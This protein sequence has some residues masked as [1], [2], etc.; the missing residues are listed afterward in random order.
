MKKLF[1]FLW[2]L[3]TFNLSYGNH[4][5]GGW[6]F[7]TY[8][9]PGASP[10]T[11]RYQ[12]ILKIYT[13]C[14][15]NAQQWC[16]TVNIS[17]FN[18]ASNNLFDVVSVPYEDSVNI[19][20][21]TAFECHP[22][23]NPIPNIC[24]KITTFSFIRELPVTFDGY[25]IAYQRCCR[26]ANIINMAPGSSSVGDTWTVQIPGTSGGDPLAYRNSSARF[27]Q[28]D[29]AI[30]CKESPFTFNFGANDPD[31]DS[32]VYEFTNAYAASQGG[33]NCTAQ[34]APPPYSFITYTS[35]FSG[36]QPLGPGVTINPQTGVVSGIAPSIP[37]TYVLTCVISE[38]K[39]GT[40]FKKSEVR[41]SLHISV[42]DCSLTSAELN[43][44]YINCS[45][46]TMQFS[47]NNN[48]PNIQTY[49]WDFGVPGI[50]NDTSNLPNPVFVYPDTGIY[51]LTFWVNKGLPCSDSTTSIVKVY[52]GFFPGFTVNGQCK[53]API[54]FTDTT[55]AVY[56]TV[57][58][59][60]W[61]F[62]KLTVT[63]DTS[64]LQNPTY[65]YGDAGTYTAE[66]IVATSVGC[67]DTIYKDV[68][69][70]DKPALTLTND[71]LICIIDTLQ[72]NAIGTGNF[73]WS[74]NYMIS[75]LT[76]PVTL[77]S[78]DVPTKYFV[79]LTDPYGCTGTD[80]V[81]VDVK[82]FV[83]LQAGADTFLCRTDATVLQLN[84]DGLRF[85]WSPPTGLN[86]PT[87]KNPV[88]TPLV[89]TSYS[90]TA[91]IGKCISY[92]TININVYDYPPGDAGPD[93]LICL[94]TNAQ[95][96]ASGG[97]FYA[98]S[99]RAFLSA[100]NI[101]NPVV[102]NPT[103]SINYIVTITD[104]LG[105]PKPVKD[106]VRVNVSRIIADA[107]P[108][109]TTV[110]L[111]Q[112]LLLRATGGINYLWSPPVW[113]NNIGIATPVALPQNNIEYVV[114]ASNNAGCFGT[115]TI[116][117]RV[118]FVKPDMYVPTAFT[119]NGD[120]KNDYFKPILI[121]M[122]T[123]ERFTVYN[124]WG[125]MVYAGADAEQGWDGTFGG[126]EQGAATYVWYAEGIDYQN[127]RKKQKGYVVLIR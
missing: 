88:A 102:V 127:N 93:T 78:P 108:R 42:S 111:G 74:P 90:V 69:I 5:K 81:F 36:F 18:T 109:D 1:I 6:I 76:N 62:G 97:S 70:T 24:Y 84:S 104:T 83:T 11:A 65:I 114:R 47:N 28:N 59:W 71:T 45:D 49:F 12:V 112:P 8:L 52:P 57:N 20:N 98:W 22:C 31:N 13:E 55:S 123:L 86:D 113:L 85:N 79:T 105:C 61:D 7:Y 32:L 119:P 68:L 15:L 122:K 17:I 63:N 19:Q 30:I 10:N 94:G 118:F 40:P 41:K 77:V 4:T 56:G 3:F 54:Q 26:I 99:P 80:S 121:G 38:Y 89:N 73:S 96:N 53:T 50:T 21:C 25:T 125:Q 58:F 110:V 39:R 66:F 124:R 46:F 117:V 100:I 120:G 34:A 75:S 67:R 92:D 51:T 107:G 126:K 91:S 95:L 43:P 82:A 14:N 72:L 27:S 115:D 33:T 116:N 37:G 106:T 103:A 60:R 29:T 35:P 9:G 64:R 87:L 101:S 2:F 23:I 16:S 48:N 44:E